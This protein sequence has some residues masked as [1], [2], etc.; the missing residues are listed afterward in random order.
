MSPARRRQGPWLY[1]VDSVG[2]QTPSDRSTPSANLDVV[3]VL[4]T[5]WK[6]F[7]KYAMSLPQSFR[8]GRVSPRSPS[9]VTHPT[10]TVSL[11]IDNAKI[12]GPCPP[13]PSSPSNSM[14]SF[15]RLSIRTSAS[16]PPGPRHDTARHTAHKSAPH[17]VLG[18]FLALLPTPHNLMISCMDLRFDRLV[19]PLPPRHKKKKTSSWIR[20]K[21]IAS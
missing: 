7:S 4:Q 9:E 1:V 14:C 20:R 2:L 6:R 13:N 21:W 12:C 10:S 3:D 16:S 5:E 17:N 19:N 15:K 11:A 18:F 8:F